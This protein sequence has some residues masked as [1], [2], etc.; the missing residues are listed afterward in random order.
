MLSDN[1]NLPTA[2]EHIFSSGTP[3]KI[4]QTVIMLIT[5]GEISIIANGEEA[6][7]RRKEFIV[8]TND[9]IV[10]FLKASSDFKFLLY[11]LYPQIIKEAFADL[12]RNSNLLTMSHIFRH[13]Q[14]DD[15][16]FNDNINLYTE[17]KEELS[18]PQHSHQKL[19]ARA[20]A[21]ILLINYI[22]LFNLNS[23]YNIKKTSKQVNVYNRFHDLLSKHCTTNREVQFYAEKLGIT[24][25]Y[26]SAVT[27]EYSD[28]N[29]SSWIDEYVITRAKSL[30]RDHKLNI[31]SVSEQLN[32]P[33]QSFFGRYFKRITGLS[34]KHFINGSNEY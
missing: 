18:R 14:C 9:S 32:F 30:L 7:M 22:N 31:K 8:I 6:T 20:Y 23:E 5:E 25:K 16:T 33:S 13:L 34:P 26:L 10:K 11:I 15:E 24:P 1:I 21:N 28:K 3:S 27:I 2:P 12:G 29:A 19:F 4:E 17:L